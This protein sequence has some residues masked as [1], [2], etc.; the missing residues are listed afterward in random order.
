MTL[1]DEDVREFQAIWKKA[2]G[3]ELPPP[4]ARQRA[5]EL[6]ELY[7]AVYGPLPSERA[8]RGSPAATP[9]QP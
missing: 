5:F 4:A 2:F 3:E 9:P 7:A 6:I 8:F 1:T